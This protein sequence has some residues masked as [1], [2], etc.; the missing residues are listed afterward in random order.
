MLV[1]YDSVEQWTYAE[2]NGSWSLGLSTQKIVVTKVGAYQSYLVN[3]QRR[4]ITSD[5]TNKLNIEQK[6]KNFDSPWETAWQYH[7]DPF[8][9][10]I[11]WKVAGK[12]F[13]F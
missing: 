8:S 4:N 9:E 3:N 6:T 5:L 10:W 12:I 7:I 2:I 11:E 13:L 1:E